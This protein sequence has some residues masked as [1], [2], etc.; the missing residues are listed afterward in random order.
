MAR[1]VLDRF[2]DSPRDDLITLRRADF[3]SLHQQR[4][5]IPGRVL[6]HAFPSHHRCRWSTFF[7]FFHLAFAYHKV[8][9]KVLGYNQRM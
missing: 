7:D 5:F 6:S 9:H 2:A 4:Q 3:I 8:Y 1:G